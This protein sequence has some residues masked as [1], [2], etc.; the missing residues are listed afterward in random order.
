MSLNLNP[1][2]LRA[3]FAISSVLLG[4]ALLVSGCGGGGSGPTPNPTATTTPGATSTPAPT[5]APV[6]TF[7]DEF[8]SGSLDTVKWSVFDGSHKIQRTQ[9]GNQPTFGQDTDGTRYMRLPLDTYLPGGATGGVELFGTEVYA[10]QKIARGNGIVFEARLRETDPN[11]GGQ[12]P[13]FFALGQKGDYGNINNPLKVDELDYELLTAGNTA[14]PRYVWTNSIN[15]FTIEQPGTGGDAYNDTTKTVAFRTAPI[16]GYTPGNWNVYRI[17]WKAGQV[18]WFINGQLIRTETS[19]VVPDED[20]GVRFNL[21]GAS[22]VWSDAYDGTLTAASTPAENKKYGLDVD[23]V[24]VT[25][26]TANTTGTLRSASGLSLSPITSA[27]RAHAGGV[28]YRSNK[29]R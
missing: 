21:W 27:D 15:D 25:P 20:L 6:G 5:S 7:A 29:R 18:Q 19:Q 22:N 14:T 3:S 1:S 4:G 12:V 17:A 13:S 2:L 11:Q 24:R 28:G 23:W 10:N 8:N 26:L 16:S 9:F